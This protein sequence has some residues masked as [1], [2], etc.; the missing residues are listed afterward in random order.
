MS[1]KVSLA[2]ALPSSLL[3]DVMDF[4]QRETLS[5]NAQTQKVGD[6]HA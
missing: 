5:Q 2:L 3:K 1:W 6:S 4:V